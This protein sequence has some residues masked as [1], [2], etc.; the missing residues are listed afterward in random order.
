VSYDSSR[1]GTHPL[2]DARVWCYVI[3]ITHKVLMNIDYYTFQD[4]LD[5]ATPEEWDQWEQTAAELELPLDYYLQEF[6]FIMPV[7]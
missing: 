5:D 1:G 7:E 4:F 2:A 3:H 6:V